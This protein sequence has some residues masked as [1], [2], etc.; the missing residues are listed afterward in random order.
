MSL[1]AAGILYTTSSYVYSDSNSSDSE[2]VASDPYLHKA[3]PDGPGGMPAP[4]P[5]DGMRLIS[6][7]EL[8]KH[9]TREDG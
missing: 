4:P 7:A 9:T 6:A 5:T 2:H 3:Q 8:A 1:A